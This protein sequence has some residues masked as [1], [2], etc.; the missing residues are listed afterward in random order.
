[1]R[2]YIEEDT[3]TTPPTLVKVPIC[4]SY[5]NYN[6]APIGSIQQY[7]GTS[8]PPGWLFCNG[9]AYSRTYYPFLFK[10]IGTTYGSGDGS[11]TFNV[12]TIPDLATGIKYIIK[13]Y[14]TA[15]AKELGID[16]GTIPDLP[17][18][19]T[20][21]D[22]T[23]TFTAIADGATWTA[24]WTGFVYFNVKNETDTTHRVSL[25]DATTN[26][27]AAYAYVKNVGG[28]TS[29]VGL[30][31]GMVVKGTTYT[32]HTTTSTSLKSALLTPVVNATEGGELPRSL[33]FGN[34][35]DVR[36]I[37][38]SLQS[39]DT[40]TAPWTGSIWLSILPTAQGTSAGFYLSEDG[41]TNTIVLGSWSR[42]VGGT[43]NEI[44]YGCGIVVKGKTY[45]VVR[46]GCS[47]QSA[48]LTPVV[49]AADPQ[50]LPEVPGKWGNIEDYTSTINSV[51]SGTDWVAP[52]TGMLSLFP[53]AGPA[54]SVNIAYRTY[55]AEVVNGT[56]LNAHIWTSSSYDANGNAYRNV[57]SG[58]IQ[59]GHTYRIDSNA[60]SQN[61]YNAMLIPYVTDSTVPVDDPGEVY[62]TTETKIGTWIDGKPIYRKVLTGTVTTYTDL[63]SRRAF[64]IPDDISL[65]DRLVDMKGSYTVNDGTSTITSSVNGIWLG[66]DMTP[67]A[68]IRYGT[69]S[70]G[71]KGVWIYTVQTIVS[72]SYELVLE[73]TK[74]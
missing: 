41:T 70:N 56:L 10:V 43:I 38:E 59:K 27:T 11:T 66:P 6:T 3:S 24:P 12:P 49:D 46:V 65:I 25:V 39:G 68:G 74:A 7:S 29:D 69:Y 44:S 37:F 32:W 52:V 8:L 50:D 58:L 22:V 42:A 17:N 23:G 67:S 18:F 57:S 54:G 5:I 34:Q 51:T 73:Y 31:G 9:S 26:L 64:A 36:S 45:H 20:P 33:T 19:G 16:P 72:A 28:L 60:P 1:M 62:T 13:A 30:S 48:M 55:I 21:I 47:I 40:W 15:D 4:G 71:N 35:V 61:V 14:S 63:G 53:P 2:Y